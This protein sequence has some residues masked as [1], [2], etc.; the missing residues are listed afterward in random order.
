LS[1]HN[2]I[3]NS[4]GSGYYQE[5]LTYFSYFCGSVLKKEEFYLPDKPR[6]HLWLL[7]QI[8]LTLCLVFLLFRNFDWIGF[9]NL[10]ER[11]PLWFYPFSF[12]LLFVAQVVYAYRWYF[13]LRSMGIHE[14]LHR[15]FEQYI[16]SIFF[17]NFLPTSI[18]GDW[19][20]IYYLGQRRGHVNVGASVFTDRLL[21]FFSMTLLAAVLIWSLKLTTVAFI[22]ARDLLTIGCIGF[23][24]L[25]LMIA[26]LPI[27]AWLRKLVMHYSFLARPGELLIRFVVRVRDASLKPQLVGA[28]IVLVTLYFI[29]VGIFY[30]IF[31]SITLDMQINM[32]P[33]SAALI[34]IAILTNLPLTVNGIGLR[35]QLHYLLFINLGIPQTASVGISLIVLFD[36]LLISA[37]GYVLWLRLRIDSQSRVPFSEDYASR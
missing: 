17:N 20:R 13:I 5:T 32:L 4:L 16:I 30:R 8:L 3:E 21:G 29:L 23:F 11:I 14:P 33:L 36:F 6:K 15:V 24:A 35:E 25:F 18:G 28:A 22:V 2:L 26:T 7:V 27:E 37:V 9:K 19:S 1:I 12:V 34:S 31:F 10:F